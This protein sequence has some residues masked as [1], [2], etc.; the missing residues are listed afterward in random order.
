MSSKNSFHHWAAKVR[1]N[2]QQG[3]RLH[4][5]HVEDQM[6]KQQDEKH[7]REESEFQNFKQFFGDENQAKKAQN[8]NKRIDSQN[9]DKK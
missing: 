1:K 6:Q 2:Q 3:K 5:N 9:E 4:H 8:N 7:E